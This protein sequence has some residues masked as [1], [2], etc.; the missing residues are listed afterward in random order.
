MRPGEGFHADQEWAALAHLVD[1]GE[2]I[3]VAAGLIS[4]ERFEVARCARERVGW[5]I[6]KRRSRG[7]PCGG[8]RGS[9]RNQGGETVALPRGVIAPLM[10]AERWG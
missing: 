10:E 2:P 8:R 6:W 9:G 7:K 3:T 4:G 5:G 1:A